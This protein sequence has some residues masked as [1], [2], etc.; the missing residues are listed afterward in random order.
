[1][2]TDRE[3]W[4][5]WPLTAHQ[6]WAWADVPDRAEAARGARARQAEAEQA[7]RQAEAR[8]SEPT[9]PSERAD[10]PEAPG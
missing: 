4:P 1:V 6:W 5:P 7:A 9:H 2:T 8:V 3:S 10:S